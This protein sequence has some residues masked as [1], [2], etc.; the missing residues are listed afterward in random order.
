MKQNTITMDLENKEFLNQPTVL[1][2]FNNPP[3]DPLELVEELKDMMI[4]S[5]GV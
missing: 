5:K 1:F 3:M 2:D 4:R